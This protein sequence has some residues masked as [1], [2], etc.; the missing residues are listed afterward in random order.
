MS[1][2]MKDTARS[3]NIFH[4]SSYNN[5]L[6]NN[7]NSLT[8]NTVEYKSEN[9][10]KYNNILNLQKTAGNQA[11]QKLIK[12]GYIQTKQKVSHP[13]D[14]YEQEADRITEQ[15]V[16]NDSFSYPSLIS[17]RDIGGDL[18]INRKCNACEMEHELEAEEEKRDLKISRKSGDTKPSTELSTNQISLIN[19]ALNESG[20]PLDKQTR[21]YMEPRLHHNFDDVRIHN[22]SNASRSAESINA[23]AYTLGNNI[24]FG[25]GQYNPLSKTGQKMIAHELTHVVQQS[26]NN[27]NQ[28]S[29]EIFRW[30][31]IEHKNI[32]NMAMIEFPYKGKINMNMASLRTN[33]FKD[34]NDLH[35]NT[36]FD[37]YLD[38]KVIA[39]DKKRGWIR[40]VVQS[41]K[42]IN[43][44]G[45]ETSVIGMTG[46]VSQELITKESEVFDQNL[47]LYPGFTL[48]YGDIVS[49]GGDLFENR[50]QLLQESKT[51]EG[52][53][54]LNKLKDAIDSESKGMAPKY[55]EPT[56]VTKEYAERYK[57][58]ALSNI[59]HFSHGGTSIQTWSI[60]HAEAIIASFD[61]GTN[62]DSALLKSALI[63][64]AFADHFLT[65]SFSAG[66]IRVPRKEIIS[67]YDNF[68]REV[69]Q[70]FIDYLANK[71]GTRIFELAQADY[72]RVRNLG[73]EEH[74]R[75]AI[76]TVH[77]RIMG[78]INSMG[79]MEKVRSAFALYVA[80]AFS[81]ILHD[82]DNKSGLRVVS[83]AHPEGWLTY[84]DG[85]LDIPENKSNLTYMLESVKLSKQDIVDAF[86]AGVDIYSRFGMSSNTKGKE[87]EAITRLG[88]VFKA[89]KPYKSLDYVPL[90]DPKVLPLP[91]WEWGKLDINMK[92]LLNNTI[93]Y[94]LTDR[95]Q[96]ELLEGLP[97][98]QEHEIDGPNINLR[99][100][101][102]ARDILN[103]F[104][105]N[106]I[107]FLEAALGKKA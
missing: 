90:P 102:A 41:G 37:L 49:M 94:Y 86:N 106:P 53:N 69:F 12:S 51:T 100:R 35:S 33:P 32:G 58:L 19:S 105:R 11:V 79:G 36:L 10:Q 72:W 1:K 38:T 34:E 99:P 16:K 59:S 66:H 61:A 87:E 95:I 27:S 30:G 67:Y 101:D 29:H 42:G 78:Q 89:L 5:H 77:D 40:V 96:A 56:T 91:S 3:N 84:G 18:R 65:D 82:N 64:N 85:K 104:R 44:K 39:L 80:G 60:Q 70:H 47:E 31:A 8:S 7:Q 97:E 43:K 50:Y 71:L 107:S 63:I 23:L 13:T 22:D 83:K 81:G 57:N 20:I 28:F 21:D 4:S 9:N 88:S 74:R 68:T 73:G 6:S 93:L 76:E 92:Q 55:E 15:I 17:E 45:K 103:E 98:R 14:P 24:V 26:T 25:N 52:R 2:Q 48:S 54:N 75:E 46:Y 62:A